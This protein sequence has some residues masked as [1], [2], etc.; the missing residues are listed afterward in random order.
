MRR[1]GVLAGLAQ[2]RRLRWQ[3]AVRVL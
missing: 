2:G 1:V 3:A